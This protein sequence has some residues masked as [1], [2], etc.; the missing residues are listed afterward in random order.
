MLIATIPYAVPAFGQQS[1]GIRGVIYDKD[2]EVP[3]PGAQ[4]LIVETNQ[5]VPT[6]AEG[7]FLFGQVEPGTYTLIFS[8]EGYTRQLKSNVV[9][10]AGS[11]VEIDMWL[12]GEFTE[13][14][15]FVVQDV[16]IGT[17]TEAALLDLRMESPALMDS[18]SSELMSQAGAGD[19]ASALRLVAGATVQDGKYAVIRGLPDRYV[20]SQMNSI[21][22]PTADADKRAVQLDQFPS[23]IIE[24]IQVSKTF[25][26]DQQGDASGGAVN[27]ILKGIPNERILKLESGISWNTQVAG[28]N[29]FLTGKGEGFNYWG[30]G[31]R[32]IPYGNLGDNW[33]GTVGVSHSEEPTDYKWSVTF[34]DKYDL[35]DEL[36]IGGLGSFFYERDSSFFKNGID[37]K[38]WVETPGARMTPQYIQ[39]SPSQGDFKTQLFNMTKASEEVKWGVLGA[40]GLETENHSISLVYIYTK[41]TESVATLAEDIRGK[42]GLNK[43]WPD[44]Y[45]PEYNN[46]DRNDSTHP[47]NLAGDAAPYIRTETLEFTERMTQTVQLS[48]RHKLT[49]FPE[50]RIRNILMFK[51]P[52]IDWG[53]STSIAGLKQPDKR[54]FGS[55]WWGESYNPGYPQWGIPSS[56]SP[57]VHRPFKPAANFT[58]GNVQRIWKDISEESRQWFLNLKFPFEQWS[59][60]EGYVKLGWFDDKVNRKYNQDSFSNFNDNSAFYEGPWEDLWSGKFPLEDHPITAADVDVDYK[61]K[62]RITAWYYMADIPV[63]SFFNIIGGYRFEKTK[64]SIINEPE[65]D[66]TWIPPGASGP[67]K[68]NPGDADVSFRQTDMLPSLGFVFKPFDK[69][70]IRGSYS[71][72]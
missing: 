70:A 69:I 71:Q 58:L 9:V 27:I 15:E 20:N 51:E 63:N 3:L 5:K 72:T 30:K 31:G 67:V 2:F 38:Y 46:Y 45:G 35:T 33:P 25:T 36:R 16:Q 42:S 6:T 44:Y 65:K 21:R 14:E 59:G 34:G 4:V 64:L 17:G 48:G 68:L 61:G 1:G 53:V 11:I 8:K 10:S 7:N 19:A 47:G 52:E 23:A 18:I 43:Y 12:A 32:K 57:A 66:V 56:T 62:Q 28:N 26:P 54:Q 60:D 41:V 22:L 29:K 39:G 50:L 24:S 49:F 13:L 40:L 37:D 55:L